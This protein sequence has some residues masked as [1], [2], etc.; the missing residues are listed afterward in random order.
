MT[1]LRFA[2]QTAEFSLTVA[3]ANHLPSNDGN[4]DSRLPI[5]IRCRNIPT[6]KLRTRKGVSLLSEIHPSGPPRH[7]PNQLM[8]F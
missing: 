4:R 2:K 1:S 5:L 6:E 7:Q 3:F 8:P